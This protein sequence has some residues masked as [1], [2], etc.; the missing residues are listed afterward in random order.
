MSA[1][2]LPRPDWSSPD[3]TAPVTR[4]GLAKLTLVEMRKM[5]DTRAGFWLL[6]SIA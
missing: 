1:P 6:L 4:P 2:T 3:A 5:I